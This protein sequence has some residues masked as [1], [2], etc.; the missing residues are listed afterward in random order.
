MPGVNYQK[1]QYLKALDKRPGTSNLYSDFD[2]PKDFDIEVELMNRRIRARSSSP[3][4]HS[5]N[6]PWYS[7]IYKQSEEE[8]G[9][10]KTLSTILY[11]PGN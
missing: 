10:M 2:L 4:A 8:S 11:W 1:K 6:F 7:E 9:E 3:S 5:K